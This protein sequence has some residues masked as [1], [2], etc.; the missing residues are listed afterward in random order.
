MEENKNVMN[1]GTVVEADATVPAPQTMNYDQTVAFTDAF[2]A[3]MHTAL[4]GFAYTEVS[5]LFKV[6]DQMKDKM[7]INLANEVIRRIA[8][9]P[10]SAVKD[11][12]HNFETNQANYLTVNT[13]KAE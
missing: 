11:F 2:V 3:D 13:P 10:Y 7:P 5:E 12:M 9:F 4:D 1:E 6:V 8:S